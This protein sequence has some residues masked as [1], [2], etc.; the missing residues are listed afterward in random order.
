MDFA[1]VILFL[2]LY[3]LRPQEWPFGLG[4]IHFVQI[5][6]LTGLASLSFRARGF[7]LRDLFRTPHDWAV[8]AFWMWI[9]V[10]SPT[11]WPTFKESASLYIFYII[12]VQTLY[13]IPRLHTF[14]GW[15][16][17]L[18][19]AVAGLALLSLH[20]FDPLDSLP[21]T[22]GSMQG[23]LIL[24]LS[25]FNNPNA[26]GHSVVPA[27][28]LLYYF[29]IWKKPVVLRALG[30]ALI[31][32]VAYC[33]FLTQS[34][35]AYIAGAATIVATLTF[36][37]PKTVQTAIIVAAVLFGGSALYALP[38]MGELNKSKT[39]EAIQGR[40]MAF[41]HGYKMMTTTDQGVGFYNWH[42]SFLAG[43]YHFKRT[44]FDKDSLK[45]PMPIVSKA[46]H[47]SYVCIGAEL[48]RPGFF[49]L[50]GIL[51]C[52]LRTLVTAKTSTPDEERIRRILFVLIVSYMVSSWMVDF[53]YRP[54]F[55]MFVAGT[56]ALH[57]HLLR[58]NEQRDGEVAETAAHA[59]QP[60]VPAW[61]A[62]LVPQPALAGALAQMGAP[63]A[64]LTMEALPAEEPEPE[65][66]PEPEAKPVSGIARA[67]NRI[68]L[69]DLTLAFAMTYAATRYWSYLITRM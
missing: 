12:I 42:T 54:T 62:R 2:V 26:L 36:G 24:N 61:R 52:C 25:I 55:F 10:S 68:G 1:V 23:R 43:K 9:V 39:D 40:V 30:S 18:V 29:C 47:S 16:T 20:G 58:L 34:K 31:V 4:A 48:G 57:R 19:A 38:R 63:S 8:L 46:A 6:M 44:H 64:V 11:P 49:L 22:N 53:E 27:I 45:K 3:Y 33:I 37:R 69:L 7:Q 59:P 41:R 66:E 35:G 5:V 17:F 13:T 32:M 67:W 15:W 28:P 51:Y 50:F 56:A 65:P 21:V 14:V 60:H